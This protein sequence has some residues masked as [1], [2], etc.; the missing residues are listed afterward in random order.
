[1][2]GKINSGSLINFFYC[3]LGLSLSFKGCLEMDLNHML[4]PAKSQE[5][6]GLEMLSQPQDRL[7]SLF[8][9]KTVKGWWPC[10][11]DSKGEK[12]LAVSIYAHASASNNSK[13]I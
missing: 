7:V 6:C 8:E 10:V 2:I 13:M 1:M 11:S 4:S 5:K 9:Q 3:V 12:I